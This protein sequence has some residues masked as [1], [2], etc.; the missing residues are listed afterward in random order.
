MIRPAKKKDINLDKTS[1]KKDIN[2]DET[3]TKKEINLTINNE[4]LKVVSMAKYLGIIIDDKLQWTQ[5]IKAINLKLSKGIGLLAKIRH[6]VPKKVLRSLYYTFIN[7]HIDYNLLNWGMAAPTNLDTVNINMKK[8]IRIINFKKRDEHSL[9]LFKELEILPLD[10]A[11]KLRQG[12][13]MWK[14]ANNYL[15]PS[16]SSNFT[17]HAVTVRSQFAMPAPRLD[18]ASKHINYAGIKLWN[19][20]PIRIK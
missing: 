5:Q 12:K 11:I 20:I 6:Y 16:L 3:S 19:E 7:P 8:A 4:A 10:K 15:P 13:F 2:P 14:L 1:I 17:T 9:P 18:L